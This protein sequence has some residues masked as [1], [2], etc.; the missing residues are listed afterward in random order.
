V[1]SGGD[2]LGV[3]ANLDLAQLGL[4]LDRNAHGQDAG[5]EIGLDL[6]GAGRVGE[7][8]PQVKYPSPARG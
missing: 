8:Q 4:L 1:A 6:V 5:L 3:G 2:R 7:V